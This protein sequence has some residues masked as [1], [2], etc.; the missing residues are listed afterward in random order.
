MRKGSIPTAKKPKKSLLCALDKRSP[1]NRH[2][3]GFCISINTL[4]N[5]LLV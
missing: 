3:A 1:Q 4:L 5:T 2:S